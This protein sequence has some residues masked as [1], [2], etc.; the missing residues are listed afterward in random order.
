VASTDFNNDGV[1]D[2]VVS[3]GRGRTPLVRVFDGRT[4]AFLTEM[5]VADPS[6]QGGV[7]VGGA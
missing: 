2:F 5:S 3:S 1:S 7:F 4:L 6:F